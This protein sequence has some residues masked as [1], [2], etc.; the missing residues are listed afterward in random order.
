MKE[1]GPLATVKARHIRVGS[2]KSF[3]SSDLHKVDR[4]GLLHLYVGIEQHRKQLNVHVRDDQGVVVLRREH[5]ATLS[6]VGRPS[7]L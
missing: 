5:E 1:G 7:A 4:G 2:P 3:S 6:Y